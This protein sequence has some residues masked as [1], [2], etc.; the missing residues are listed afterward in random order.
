MPP[1]AARAILG[2]KVDAAL[3]FS[4]RSAETFAACVH[5]MGLDTSAIMAVCISENTASALGGLKFREIRAAPAPNQDS[6][7]ASL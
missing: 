1:N 4:P 2:G 5:R 6:L 3:F 7:L